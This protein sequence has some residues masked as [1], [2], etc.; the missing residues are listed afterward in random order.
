MPIYHQRICDSSGRILNT[1][2]V[3]LPGLQQAMAHANMG[4]R[5]MMCQRQEQL[6][7]PKGRVEISDCDGHTLAR[8]YCAEVI[9][10]SR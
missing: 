5:N 9:A 2:K 8:V 1:A 10:S 3:E 6:F 7:D 4:V